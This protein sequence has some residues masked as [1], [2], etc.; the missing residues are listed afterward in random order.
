MK[1][2]AAAALSQRF[3]V[4]LRDGS[5]PDGQDGSRLGER[6]RVEP[7]LLEADTPKRNTSVL[8]KKA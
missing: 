8:D 2:Q 5:L 1:I 7:G 6:G 4:S 3:N